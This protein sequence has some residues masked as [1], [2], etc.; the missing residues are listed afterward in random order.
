MN[1]ILK[2][3]RS[4]DSE[5]IPLFDEKMRRAQ[6]AAM[7][8]QWN[9]FM[10][11][12]K[13][14]KID[15]FGWFDLLGNTAIHVVTRSNKPQLL[16]ELLQM[17]P[18][19]D[20]RWRAVRTKN[21]EENTVLHEVIFCK[22]VEMADVVLKYDKSAEGEVSEEMNRSLLEMTNIKGETPLFRAAKYGKLKMLKHLADHLAKHNKVGDIQRHLHRALD[23]FSAL[24]ASVIGQYFDV[25]LWLVRLDQGLALEKGQKDQ[26]GFTCLQLLSKMPHV[27]RSHSSMGL[28]KRFIYHLLPDE[29]YEIGDGESLKL[30]SHGKDLESGKFDDRN[31]PKSVISKINYSFWKR[32]A[33]EFEG[34]N[35]MWKQKK[36][37][38]LAES[39]ADILVECDLS[40]QVSCDNYKRTLIVMPSLPCN[41]AKR[42]NQIEAKRQQREDEQKRQ[43]EKPKSSREESLTYN[44]T[45]L[46]IAASNGIVEIVER[47]LDVNPE[48][49][50]HVSN[51][52]QNILHMAIKHRQME[53]FKI[54]KR[55]KGLKSLVP[56]I[57]SEG[58]TI[59]HQVARMDYYKGGHLAGVAFQLQDE[60]H[61]Y[62]RVRK[63]VPHHY[64]MHCD[65][66]GQT[67]GD[68]LELDHDQMVKNAQKWLKETAQ[69]CS[70][71]AVLVATVVFAA[72]YTIPGGSEGGTPVFLR[73]PIFLFFTVMDVVGL[74]TSLASVVMF[75]S[76]LTSPCELWDFHKSLPR[77]LNLGF[78]FL[79]FSLITTM[80]AFSATILLT[81][82]LEWKNWTSTL[83]YGA[84]FFPVTVFGIIQF[85]VYMVAESM[86]KQ[87][88]KQVKKVLPSRLIKCFTKRNERKYF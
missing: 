70:T 54:I 88:G 82:R 49:I 55:K 7:A 69:S 37:H 50:H 64:H 32:F 44:Y 61:W 52:E 59:L 24:H 25:A 17:L 35:D 38:R 58:R 86:V 72:A 1:R 76:I 41:V 43:L 19:E 83:V 14:E 2:D 53:I 73:S 20:H 10:R 63:I 46:L 31:F 18:D 34:I 13:E 75:L 15:M 30:F 79:F 65:E 36:K 40:W 78:A 84:A 62:D 48:A 11:I 5:K 26:R 87:L 80:L 60:L 28:V 81:I 3:T 22:K 29:G 42:R 51:D 33:K 9:E 45:P 74:A 57:T 47:I 16:I 12:I 85:P 4:S 66:D 6:K 77:K 68:V 23:N 39:L 56:R 71:V 67:P 21:R 27:F 8:N